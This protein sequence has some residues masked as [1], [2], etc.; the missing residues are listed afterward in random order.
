MT[1][2]QMYKC[3]NKI[4]RLNMFHLFKVSYLILDLKSIFEKINYAKNKISFIISLVI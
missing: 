2:G 3:G 1:D 4:K